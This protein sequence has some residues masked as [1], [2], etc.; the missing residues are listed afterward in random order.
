M[1]CTQ[2][3]VKKGLI[4]EPG[5]EID[6]K[7]GSTLSAQREKALRK[8]P[9]ERACVPGTHTPTQTPATRAGTTEQQ[10]GGAGLEPGV[11]KGRPGIAATRTAE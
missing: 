6:K 8:K 11:P 10:H 9:Q 7:S 1:L 3:F 4:L 2:G 5:Q